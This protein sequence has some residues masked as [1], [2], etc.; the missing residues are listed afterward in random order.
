MARLSLLRSLSLLR[1][2]LRSLKLVSLPLA[3]AS[4]AFADPPPTL[5]VSPRPLLRDLHYRLV[6]E[7]RPQGELGPL[8]FPL[9]RDTR[10]VIEA[11]VTDEVG[12]DL[13]VHISVLCDT[14]APVALQP[15][16]MHNAHPRDRLI[17]VPKGCFE[18]LRNH[19]SA[20]HLP[21][22]NARFQ[23]HTHRPETLTRPITPRYTLGAW[24]LKALN[25]QELLSAPLAPLKYS[26]TLSLIPPSRLSPKALLTHRRCTPLEASTGAPTA[27]PLE[28]IGEVISLASQHEAQ[29]DHFSPPSVGCFVLSATSPHTSW[30]RIRD[31]H[32]VVGAP[33]LLEVK[34]T[35]VRHSLLGYTT[36]SG[37]VAASAE[38][39]PWGGAWEQARGRLRARL[40]VGDD[41]RVIAEGPV[42]PSGAWRLRPEERVSPEL[43]LWVV[44][45]DPSRT[46][47]ALP[48][49]V[50]VPARALSA[51]A[52]FTLRARPL[53]FGGLGLWL[54]LS[55]CLSL[56]RAHG[57]AWILRLKG[58]GAHEPH[59][60]QGGAGD[61]LEPSIRPLSPNKTGEVS[62]RFELR[63]A[64]TRA[65][66]SGEVLLTLPPSLIHPWVTAAPRPPEAEVM[67][68]SEVRAGEQL[69]LTSTRCEAL[70]GEGASTLWVWATATGYEPAA[71][72]LP[73]PLTAPAQLTLPL[74]P[75]R[76]ALKR[77]LALAFPHSFGRLPLSA[78]SEQ[79][80]RSGDSR[81]SALIWQ[82]EALLYQSERSDPEVAPSAHLT[83]ARALAVG[84]WLCEGR[85]HLYFPPRDA[86]RGA[87]T[88]PPAL[89]APQ[90]P[91]ATPQAEPVRS[92]V[93]A[94]ISLI[95]LISLT[96]LTWLTSITSITCLTASLLSTSA[97]AA[98]SDGPLSPI[99]EP[100]TWR[101][102]EG[103]VERRCGAPLTRPAR[104]LSLDT[105]PVSEGL[106]LIAPHAPLDDLLPWVRRGGVAL[107]L[108]DDSS[109][110]PAR[111]ALT[112][113]G[114][115][116]LLPPRPPHP[117]LRALWWARPRADMRY[118]SF[119]GSGSAT[120]TESPS[121]LRS[122]ISPL[123]VD[124]EGAS[125]GYH[126]SSGEGRLLLLGDAAAVSDQLLPEG[127]STLA[128]YLAALFED[129]SAPPAS[130]PP[131]SAPTPSQRPRP[132]EPRCAVTLIGQDPLLLSSHAPPPSDPSPLDQLTR[133]LQDTLR[134][135]QAASHLN[136]LNSP[137]ARVLL[138]LLL[139]ST[140]RALVA[141]LK[142]PSPPLPPP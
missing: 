127:P 24:A 93:S 61:P 59:E 3:L 124:Q 35:E 31:A 64:L 22:L 10:L 74:W 95:W 130:A 69:T 33:G 87:P 115:T 63:D 120:F 1:A 106:L 123:W 67:C 135:A 112:L 121:V 51:V 111:E 5:Y 45:G 46:P 32:L 94:L 141:R 83:L 18:A 7:Y 19:T 11:Y 79:L 38:G 88:S 139:T 85:P 91:L 132:Q 73:T 105:L 117:R 44:I 40:S 108:L 6:T 75:A 55:L 56:Y 82:A 138:A 60:T 9:D 62:L 42:D 2:L 8:T 107:L 103:E 134:E 109:V 76:D 68:A 29:D 70:K 102:L 12:A 21:T 43:P 78:L 28:A 13:E 48:A 133:A 92:A 52:R 125:V 129:P 122:N 30:Q 96:W 54:C 50:E 140:L 39:R 4:P 118:T 72:E 71:L 15:S 97:L 101:R 57:R 137:A 131:A 104:P 84:W 66:I 99:L 119:L 136:T 49:R 77:Q 23:A 17:S 128:R 26:L 110:E 89:E 65:P 116:P 86:R 14:D 27:A 80:A 81:R 25:P 90:G 113:L 58:R 114:F 34:V 16:M 142:R 36:L 20:S 41:P 100:L 98:P 53:V 47:L 37:S 126:F